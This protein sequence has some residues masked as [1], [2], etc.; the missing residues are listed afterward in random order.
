MKNRVA[1]V[2]LPFEIENVYVF[3]LYSNVKVSCTVPG[4]SSVPRA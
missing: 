1:F 3:G 2:H 4:I